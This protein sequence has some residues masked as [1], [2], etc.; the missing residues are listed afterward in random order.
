[1]IDKNFKEVF[2]KRKISII[3]LSVLFPIACFLLIGIFSFS[4]VSFASY[5]DDYGGCYYVGKNSV[6]NMTGGVV[7]G[8]TSKRGG[9]VYVDSGGIFKFSGGTIA[10]NTASNGLFSFGGDIYN[11]GTFQMTGGTVGANG[12]T[13]AYGIYN[14]GTMSIYGGT[15]YDGVFS[16]N[17]FETKMSSKIYGKITLAGT[18]ILTVADYA[19]TTP[20][21][22]IALQSSRKT[23]AFLV[24]KGS[25]S[26]PDIS[27]LSVSGYDKNLYKVSASWNMFG[28]YANSYVLSLVDKEQYLPSTWK[29]EIASNDNMTTT[30]DPTLL[31]SIKFVSSIPSGYSKIGTL[32]TG[33]YVYKGA[34]TTE[35]AF[36]GTKIYAP[37]NSKALFEGLSALTEIDLSVFDTYIVTSMEHMFYNCSG[38]T[39]LDTSNFN[40]SKVTNMYGMFSH[41]TG[42]T[43]LDVSNFD[44]SKVTNISY[45]FSS[46]TLL[47]S[48]DTSNFNTSNVTDMSGLFRGCNAL[49]SVSISGFNT[50]KV[51]NMSN[52]FYDCNKLTS[53]DVLNFDTSSVT[54]MSYMFAYCRNV[55]SIDVSNFNTSKVTDMSGM[56]ASCSNI[57]V[58]DLLSF[59]T[60]NVVLLSNMFDG[61]SKLTSLDL[62]CFDTTNVTDMPAMFVGCSKLEWLDVSSFNTAKVKNFS[63]MFSYCVK[64]ESLNVGGFVT[65]SATNMSSMF[66]SCYGLK[67]LDL[68]GFNMT[69]VTNVSE[70]LNLSSTSKIEFLK[71]PYK[72][73][74][75]IPIVTGSVLYD[76]STEAVVSSVPANITT[77]K[78]FVV[79]AVLTFN[80]LGGTT[81]SS[82]K[83][84]LYTKSYGTLAS[85]SK[86]GYDFVGWSRNYFD[87]E[88]IVFGFTNCTRVGTTFTFDTG[89]TNTADGSKCFQV[90]KFLNNTYL[91]DVFSSYNAGKVNFVFTK[92]SSFNQLRFKLN[93]NKADGACIFDV[94]NLPDGDYVMQ[95]NIESLAM[96]KM[97]VKDLMIEQNAK[98]VATDFVNSVVSSSTINNFVF[99]HTL[100]AWWEEIKTS[101][102]PST[103]KTEV[104]SND[105]MTTTVDPSQLTS[106]K[107][108][109]AV[110][111]GYSRIGTLSTGLAVYRGSSINEIAFV[112]KKIYAPQNCTNL[113]YNLENLITIDT[114]NFDTSKVVNMYCMFC[115]CSKLTTL[116]VSNFD[117]SK[118]TRMSNMFNSCSS[119]T[120]LDVSNFDTSSVT[121]LAYMFHNCSSLTTLDVS[122]FNT[123]NVS[124]LNS[125]FYGCSKLTNIDVSGFDTSK[126]TS[127]TG[128]F[129]GC[130]SL[131]S[132]D[133]SGFDTTRV[134]DMS[135]MFYNC[136]KITTLDVSGFNTTKVTNMSYLFAG[137]SGLTSIDVDVF[138]TSNVTTMTGMF[139]LCTGLTSLNVSGFDT[140]KVVSMNNMFGSCRNLTELD[141]GNFDTS[142]VTDMNNM[143]RQCNKL[144]SLNVSNFNTS[145]V[146]SMYCMFY[147]LDLVTSLDLTNFDTSNVTDMGSMFKDCYNLTSLDLSSFNMANVTEATS[148]LE[149]RFLSASYET[150]YIKLFKTPYN[151]TMELAISTNSSL[152]DISSGASVSSVPANLTK[153][154]TFATKVSL[155]FNANGGSCNT[156]SLSV[157]YGVSL[158]DQGVSLPTATKSGF[159]F[160]GWYESAS[161]VIKYTNTSIFVENKTLYAKFNESSA[162][163]G[164]GSNEQ[165]Y[166]ED[167]VKEGTSGVMFC[168]DYIENI[169]SIAFLSAYN[170][171]LAR[172][173]LDESVIET[174]GS[175]NVC[176][177]TPKQASI[178]NIMG[179]QVL[180]FVPMS[181]DSYIA[182]D[183]DEFIFNLKNVLSSATA[184]DLRGWDPS[185]WNQGSLSVP[186]NVEKIVLPYGFSEIVSLANSQTKIY[187][188]SGG[189]Y[190]NTQS[191]ASSSNLTNSGFELVKAF[192]FE[193]EQMK[194]DK[195]IGDEKIID[196]KRKIKVVSNMK[197][198]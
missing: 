51:T 136:S 194:I 120:T 158:S 66:Y 88:R 126:I 118:V 179:D 23:G 140:S 169:V 75:E 103:W 28:T 117:T 162:N 180:C 172:Y 109:S 124:S 111:S 116:D 127:M 57:S 110:P 36:V 102:L 77:S 30:I 176:F 54:S 173:T 152:Y 55:S 68:S 81:S 16:M 65:S 43:S 112:C 53:L 115:K 48:V 160:L 2:V 80:P 87:V 155:S 167:L 130:L 13:K 39:T 3:V 187:T 18:S 108:V 183:S 157:Y 84:A 49:T 138:D 100:F 192:M 31:T 73:T 104:A 195:N 46:C 99:D 44:T 182:F 131:K 42:V 119:L 79:G 188:Y 142:N 189:S 141:V 25:A 96:N 52:M 63:R 114:S 82:S 14:T 113:F 86:R 74:T 164:F 166:L 137:C 27:K 197:N 174:V 154:K 95:A 33:L 132:I 85:A 133:V 6:L 7:S 101:S 17:S 92:T 122:G 161:S 21:Y 67:S 184:L 123:A 60:A 11:A 150:N 15:I 144:T 129:R 128:M 191:F 145:K 159:D 143:F 32:S 170:N 163:T 58:L 50:A 29:A 5:A 186:A 193:K 1:M 107:F 139:T 147:N 198:E 175:F 121:S 151:N 105:Y 72:N 22:D 37:E 196:T 24:L 148:M 125:M 62:S 47:Q 64:L 153:S 56:F 134:I 94:S 185:T 76:I 78:T 90:Q 12:V 97:V 41:C 35:I 165:E 70:M 171:S 34:S 20:S 98:N 83:I 45:M 59:N 177:G 91:T 4:N 156:S 135:F 26:Q 38:L 89:T 71:T 10:N 40:T 146:K 168:G 8:F 61:C 190:S 69:N 178:K 181:T 149:F 106:I 93:G 9:G 19:G